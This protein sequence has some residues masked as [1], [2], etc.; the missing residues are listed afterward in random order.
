M[1]DK[2]TNKILNLKHILPYYVTMQCRAIA[3]KKMLHDRTPED[4]GKMFL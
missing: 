1:C 2:T 3:P 4:F